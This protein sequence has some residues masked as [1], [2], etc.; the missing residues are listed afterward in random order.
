MTSIAE[1]LVGKI[2]KCLKSHFQAK[3]E[4]LL[5]QEVDHMLQI[6]EQVNSYYA[7]PAKKRSSD[8]QLAQFKHKLLDQIDT[9]WSKPESQDLAVLHESFLHELQGILEDVSIYQTVEQSHDRFIAISSDPAWVRIFKLGK[10]LIYHLTCLPNG[11]ANL[12]R[13]EKIHKPY[14]KHEI[15]LRNLAKKHF[16]V[17]VLLDLQDATEMLY[18]GVASEYV[19]LKEW[20]EKLSHGDTEASKIDA[21]DMLNFKNELGKSL[22]RKIKEITGPKAVKF[23]L[24][25][26]K[27]G[28]FE[29]PEARLSNEII[30]NKVE[31]AKSQWSLNDLEWR[32]T[33]YALFEEWRMDLNINLLKHKTL[34]SLFEFQSAQ[35][36]KI[37]DYIGP[38]M[39]EI[40]SFIDESISS[41]SKEHESIAK[42]LKRLNYQAVKKLDKEVVPRLCDKLSNQTVINLINKLEVSIANQVEELSDERVIVKSGSYNAPIKSEDLNVI[43]PHELIAFE[44]L[45]I[46]KKQVELI[47]QGSFSS[48]ERMVENVKDLDHIITFSLSSGIAS[49]EQQRD[50]Q[51]AISIA[52]E[53][54]K[55]AVARLIEERNQL[56]EAM[57]VNGNELETVI[58][59]FCDGV[60]ELTFNE[61]VR[62]LRMR[63]TKAKATQQAKEVRQ[64]LEE[65]M[66]TRK[67]RVA[68]VL[69][70]IYNDVRHKLN[71]L[72][73]S[74]VLTAKKPEISKQVSD[75]LLESQQAIDKLPLIYK[76]LYQI[77]PLEDLEL[78][79]GRK[80]EF[81]TL[82]KAFESWQ[83]G[84]YAA[85][86]VLGEKW[87]GL[88]SFINYSL[89]HA[90]FPFTIT[91][92]KLEGNGCNEDHFI[93][94]MRTTFKNDTFTQLEEVINYLNSSSKRVVILEDIQNL[95]Q[96]K[97]N[98][99]EAMQML[100]QIVNKTYK[101]VFWII[102]S[103]VYTW[104]YLEKTININ[105]YFSYV[106]ELKTMTSDQIISI[107]WKRNRISGFKIQFETDAGSA[108]DKKF[109]K[110]NEAEQQQWLKKKFFSELNSF[111]QSN[112]S[113]ALIYWLLSTKEVDDSSITVGTFKKP[114][115]N[116]LTVLAMDKI[117]ALHA[118]I[119][120]DGL[121]I[122]QLAQVLNVTVKSCELILL[123][124]LEDGILVKTHE[125]YMINPIVY[126]NTISLL[127]SRNLIH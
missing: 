119:L 93:Q 58:N 32:N 120:H 18:S 104:S 45:P 127:K 79:E 99:F 74:F 52:E 72:S 46:F 8:A 11:I 49:M 113:L 67:K 42:E 60:M 116:F 13:K 95:F 31:S 35:F 115:L 108:D 103:T 112:I 121:T 80:D 34:A 69:L 96:R 56:N 78:F 73:E 125:A 4:E 64:R 59:T 61:N 91:R 38:E 75:F 3:V 15:P 33:N 82:K 92:M 100:F 83:K 117:Y 48:L 89:S 88:T 81:V 51:E 26:E 19:N 47:K 77:E 27:A 105:E 85:T 87:G 2:D 102:S 20:E 126:R 22:K 24:E 55:R 29:L 57:I 76:R 71:S 68:L 39:D 84:H 123:A 43:S 41:L 101:N 63:I 107:I 17:Q 114:N 37:D 36:K 90:R 23:E 5:D 7:L 70:G 53:G 50:P 109:K 62:Q 25:Y 111:A 122:E 66:T 10:R 12:F 106:I 1:E 54:L 94:V 14:W 44:T 9:L 97:V 6:V 118:L 21:D 124:L 65:K 28:T 30:Y 16:L 110:L 86:V 40:K 98:G